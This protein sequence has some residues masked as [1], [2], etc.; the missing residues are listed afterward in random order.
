MAG[1]IRGTARLPGVG[2]TP[3]HHS[4]SYFF[5][6]L[7]LLLPLFL[8]SS[9][10]PSLSVSKNP[11]FLSLSHTPTRLD[12]WW[13]IERDMMSTSGAGRYM[14]FPPSP[15]APPSPHLSG[16]RSTPLSDP[17]KYIYIHSR[18]SLLI[19]AYYVLFL[20]FLF[21]DSFLK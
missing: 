8:L 5:T 3:L 6:L 15:S 18:S 7:L 2:P 21:K 16:L 13:Q 1:W 17:D 19:V 4:L 12:Q 20:E 14:A 9:Y 11:F 10:F